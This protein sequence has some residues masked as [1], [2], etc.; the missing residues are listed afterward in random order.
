MT[1]DFN[2]EDTDQ[3]S[4]SSD[5]L[6][7]EDFSTT[8]NGSIYQPSVIPENLINKS[9]V[10]ISCFP[11]KIDFS[12]IYPNSIAHQKILIINTGMV[13]EYLSVR[14]EGNP[15]FT[16]N[17]TGITL[18]PNASQSLI[19]SFRPL[20]SREYSSYLF[21]DG[22][23]Q[24]RLPVTGICLPSPLEV[25]SENDLIWSQFNSKQ[26]SA[27]VPIKN[28]SNNETLHVEFSTNCPAF[29][30]MPELID[31]EPKTSEHVTI[32]YLPNQELNKVPHFHIRCESTGDFIS[33]T[34]RIV[35]VS[36]IDFG[37]IIIGKNSR[38]VTNLM[39]N[40]VNK[41]NISEIKV[42]FPFSK[43]IIS[44]QLFF[45]FSP[46][47]GG[48]F[49]ETIYIENNQFDLMGEGVEMPFSI[50]LENMRIQNLT[51]EPISLSFALDTS[52][53]MIIP[54]Q[55]ELQA[56][57]W[58]FLN[59]NQQKSQILTITYHRNDKNDFIWKFDLPDDNENMYESPNQKSLK[60]SMKN[61][62]SMISP[63]QQKS[64]NFEESSI[65]LK[66]DL[67]FPVSDNI[68]THPSF[69][70]FFQSITYASFIVT[71]VDSFEADGPSWIGFPS[72]IEVDCPIDIECKR[73]PSLITLDKIVIT[74]ENSLPHELPIIGYQGKSHITCVD[75]S[76]LTYALDDHYVT[77]IEVR[78]SGDLPAFVIFTA[79][80]ETKH[81]VRIHPV[82]T[83][84]ESDE[85]QMFEFIVDSKPEGGLSIPIVL[86]SCDEILRQMRAVIFK[87][88]FF[89]SDVPIDITQVLQ[90]KSVLR[91]IKPK[92]FHSVFKKLLFAKEIE[93]YTFEKSNLKRIAV[94]PLLIESC[95]NNTN[96]LSVVNMSSSTIAFQIHSRHRGI[97]VTPSNAIIKG[98]SEIAISV[99]TICPVDSE[100][101]IEYEDDTITVPV[102]CISSPLSPPVKKEKKQKSL[103]IDPKML[104]FGICYIDQKERKANVKV[105]NLT[106]KKLNIAIQSSERN[107]KFP[108]KPFKYPVS[109]RISPFSTSEFI[110]EFSPESEF[111]FEE[112]L[113]IEANNESHYM[114]IVGNGASRKY[115]N[116]VGTESS[117]L[118]F[119]PCEVGRVQRGRIRILNQKDRKCNIIASS[120]FPF[121]CPIPRFSVEPN[122]YVLCPIHFSPKAEGKFTGYATFE[123]DT[124]D[125]FRVGLSGRAVLPK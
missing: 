68:V 45:N 5:L 119:P 98:Y 104:D 30:V 41:M 8:L 21:L 26:L 76:A 108:T 52:Q 102:K 40:S 32:R 38:K 109:L 89:R 19:I 11:P 101:L 70:P 12:P 74:S 1:D 14:L 13:S 84:I 55:T 112:V 20:K 87:D 99:K 100:I 65:E 78:N 80:D 4:S 56:K 48:H 64:L 107:W 88:D 90:L 120:L 111:N 79:T 75:R 15:V 96:K 43:E 62:R 83:I 60:N 113:L 46:K 121:I 59:M 106:H 125:T 63:S 110:V 69:I 44:D 7:S 91:N 6:K 53:S 49:H 27:Y 86:Y 33:R 35:S 67:L 71:G 17:M 105:T 117:N 23:H 122:C 29:K 50:N 51:N 42:N 2:I 16:V 114:K 123:S 39:I 3:L 22:R 57:A 95:V 93:L 81:N 9:Q 25:P 73:F 24:T 103:K 36:I 54:Q 61:N 34:L 118:A 82:A 28:K 85:S 77:K 94:Y 115:N 31:I 97:C 116:F 92:E 47:E 10:E 66:K 58:T 18:E 37:S 72:D 124:S